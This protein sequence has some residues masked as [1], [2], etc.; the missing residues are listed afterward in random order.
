MSTSGNVQ[1]QP[2]WRRMKA[3]IVVL[4]LLRGSLLLMSEPTPA[5]RDITV[6]DIVEM[7]RWADEDYFWGANPIDRV[8]QFS[9]DGEHFVI[10]LRKGNVATNVNEYSIYL[11]NTSSVFRSHK[12]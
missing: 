7:T 10:V 6:K 4:L 3:G 12:P 1:T 8:A 5:K 9:P 11:F 2:T